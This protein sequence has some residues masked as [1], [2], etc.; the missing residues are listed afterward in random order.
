MST[1]L[2]HERGLNKVIKSH[3]ELVPMVM[4]YYIIILGTQRYNNST[5]R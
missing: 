4:E 1:L 2:E 5:T 3:L